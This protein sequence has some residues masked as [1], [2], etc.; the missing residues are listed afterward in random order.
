MRYII[1]RDDDTNALTPA[2]C[3]ERLYRPF[4]DRGLPVNLA[5]IPN[6]RT[7]ARRADGRPE[8]FLH[9]GNSGAGAHAWIGRNRELVAYLRSHPAYHIVQHGYD[10]SLYEFGSHDTHDLARRLDR[11]A[12]RLMQA[13]FPRPE[14]FVAPHDRISRES[15]AALTSRYR[16]VSTGWFEWRR[17]P[18]RWWAAYAFRKLRRRPHWRAGRTLF[19]SH[20]GCL[21]SRFRDREGMLDRVRAAVAAQPLTVL[22]THWWEYFPDGRPDEAFIGLLHRTA[23]FLASEPDLQVVSFA[24]LAQNPLR[25]TEP[26]LRSCLGPQRARR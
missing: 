5:T 15:F 14:T 26:K 23:E 21:L 20:P 10:H 24:E 2:D 12:E 19:L 1:L 8:G 3:L 22:V 25:C 16:V 7:D 6:V 4:L 9:G 17:V 18:P 11:G 13:G